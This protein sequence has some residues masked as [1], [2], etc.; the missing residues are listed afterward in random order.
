MVFVRFSGQA[1]LDSM[2]LDEMAQKYAAYGLPFPPKSAVLEQAAFRDKDV[3]GKVWLNPYGDLVL[4]RPKKETADIAFDRP[5]LNKFSGDRAFIPVP[6]EIKTFEKFPL[7]RTSSDQFAEDVILALVIQEHVRGHD[8][9]AKFLYASLT[10]LAPF[11]RIAESELD[12][13]LPPFT[14][15]ALLARQYWENQLVE[16]NC[17]RR[18]VLSRLEAIFKDAPSV[19]LP[20]DLSLLEGL[21]MTI[22][23]ATAAPKPCETLVDRLCDSH[24]ALTMWST[25]PEIL[26]VI[27]AGFDAIPALLKHIDDPR[28]TRATVQSYRGSFEPVHPS[29]PYVLTVGS[30]CNSILRA[31]ANRE[32][33]TPENFGPSAEAWWKV[34]KA[35]SE[36]HYFE[37]V[38]SQMPYGLATYVI[39]RAY[40]SRY[41]SE[42]SNLVTFALQKKYSAAET[43]IWELREAPVSF[44]E[45]QR[46]CVEAMRSGNS[47]LIIPAERVMNT[48]KLPARD[49]ELT[50]V[51]AALPDHLSRPAW[52]DQ[53]ARLSCLALD[54][55]EENVWK[56]LTEATRRADT[57]MRMEL[58]EHTSQFGALTKN[59]RPFLTYLSAFFDDQSVAGDDHPTVYSLRVG[60][61]ALS[62]AAR[63]FGITT[64]TKFSPENQW[65][66]LR[67][68]VKDRIAAL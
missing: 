8:D 34:A 14:K 23:H 21:R 30:L 63:V 66:D 3:F 19:A 26:A 47:A 39:T 40:A 53:E 37:E 42:F 32:I 5:I 35:K 56:S 33:E 7:E 29:T 65:K 46:V 15:V 41:R 13:T 55:S 51:F 57:D 59:Y 68:Q 31:Y 45:K 38:E 9:I 50:R 58:I 60:D 62:L 27:D 48:L 49:K 16:T 28:V 18:I 10:N 61:E 20:R 12:D 22:N 6:D 67:K 25:S 1:T 64:L 17:D 36:R 24:E 52:N 43:M 2:A 54:S 4:S 44:G 11:R